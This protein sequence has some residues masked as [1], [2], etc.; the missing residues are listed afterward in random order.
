[1]GVGELA[2]WT[3]QIPSRTRVIYLIE[4]LIE[5]VKG[6]VLQSQSYRISTTQGM[7]RISKRSP[8]EVPVLIM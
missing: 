3:A 6:L 4:E 7:D 5:H 2:G 8:S 1:M